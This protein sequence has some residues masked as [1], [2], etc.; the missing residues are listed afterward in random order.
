MFGKTQGTGLQVRGG[1][2]PLSNADPLKCTRPA[3][4]ARDIRTPVDI[5]DFS[6]GEFD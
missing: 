3:R 6:N 1:W 2:I 5:G 4:T